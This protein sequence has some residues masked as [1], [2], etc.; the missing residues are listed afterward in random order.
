M[1]LHAISRYFSHRQGDVV[2]LQTEKDPPPADPS[3]TLP[4]MGGS[5]YNRQLRYRWSSRRLRAT[6][7]AEN[8]NSSLN[9][10]RQTFNTPRSPLTI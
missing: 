7:N 10:N 9:V 1:R 6:E 5:G 3:P 2:S 4:S 8:G